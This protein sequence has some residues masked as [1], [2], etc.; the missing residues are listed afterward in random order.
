MK[1]WPFHR[2]ATRS[3]ATPSSTQPSEHVLSL[4]SPDEVQSLGGLPVEGIAGYFE[5]ESMSVEAFRQNSAFVDFMHEVIRTAGPNDSE[6]RL[7]AQEQGDGWVYIIDLR[8]PEGPS[9]HVPPEDIIGAFEVQ[10]GRI[11]ADS[12]QASSKHRVYTRDGIVCLPP[13]LRR[14]LVKRLSKVS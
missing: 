13:S 1:I 6:L 7:A 10:N 8:T 12:Y 9:G 5:D 11:V 3:K 14:A 2:K 4:L